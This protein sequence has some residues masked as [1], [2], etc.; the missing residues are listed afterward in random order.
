MNRTAPN[1]LHALF[2]TILS[3]AL[4]AQTTLSSGKQ[5]T[6]AVGSSKAVEL[7]I[8]S[9][10]IAASFEGTPASQGHVFVVLNVRWTNILPPQ[11]SAFMP[12]L[13]P[14]VHEHLHL[15]VNGEAGATLVNDRFNGKDV[16]SATAQKIVHGAD[17]AGRYVF[18]ARSPVTSLELDYFDN[19]YGNIKIPIAGSAPAAPRGAIAGPVTSGGLVASVTDVQ[20]VAAIGDRKARAGARLVVVSIL[21]QGAAS[22]GDNFLEIKPAEIARLIENSGYVYAAADVQDVEGVWSDTVRFVPGSPSR[23]KLV[24]EVPAQHAPL[25]LSIMVP[26]EA[27]PVRLPLSAAA[28]TPTPKPSAMATVPDGATGAFYLYASRRA[29]TYGDQTADAGHEFLVLDVGLENRTDSGIEFQTQEQIQLL[30]GSEEISSTDDDL[31]AAPRAL[32][33]NGVVPPHTLGRYEIPFRVPAG[34]SNFI[35]YYRGFESE[36]KIPLGGVP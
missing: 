16:L 12:Y 31:A 18:D 11:D 6:T 28:A 7:R 34:R 8:D 22:V 21:G 4:S 35:V 23:G 1:A 33:E 25:A 13:I 3:V 24:F 10:E 32:P 5:P 15:I 17:V 9:D 19:S 14:D 2:V 26:G 27:K 30:N 29:K 20:E 36:K